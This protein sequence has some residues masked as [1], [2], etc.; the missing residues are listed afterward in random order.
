M[1]LNGHVDPDLFDVFM[2]RQVYL[3]YARQFLDPE[4]IDDVVPERIPGYAPPPA[5]A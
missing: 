1:K 4:Q 2:W 5:G 3:K